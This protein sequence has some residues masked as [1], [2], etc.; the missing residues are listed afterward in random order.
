MKTAKIISVIL[1]FVLTGCEK[2]VDLD[3]DN[4]SGQLVIEGNI[5]NLAEPHFVRITRSVSFTQ[6]NQY[7]AVT[8]ALVIISDNISLNDTLTYL[9]DGYYVTSG[10]NAG[11]PGRNYQLKV[12]VD[13]KT[14][15]AQCELPEMVPLD[16]LRIVQMTN[17]GVTS[18]DVLPEYI[19]P[20]IPGNFYGFAV[21][22]SGQRGITFEVESDNIGN[23][24]ANQRGLEIPSAEDNPVNTGDTI[25]VEMRSIAPQ[26]YTYF[27]ALAQIAGNGLGGGSTPANP[28]SNIIG[29]ALGYF[30]AHTKQLRSITIQ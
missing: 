13:S 11:V 18:Y 23:G 25:T 12:L 27:N 22:A 29:G 19:D 8:N 2:E 7:P 30:S 4:K 24:V 1:L 10:L 28:P 3:L 9:T 16:G 20:S 14:Y 21:T 6:S 5:T 26:L 17:L 15:T